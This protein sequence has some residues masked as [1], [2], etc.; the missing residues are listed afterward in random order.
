[1][2]RDGKDSAQELVGKTKS[3]STGSE[4]EAGEGREKESV[5][6]RQRRQAIADL[7]SPPKFSESLYFSALAA[8]SSEVSV[9]DPPRLRLVLPQLTHRHAAT[10]LT[11]VL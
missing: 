2:S 11:A 1:M 5:S 9:D 3:R 6:L 4:S 10:V 7:R 8:F